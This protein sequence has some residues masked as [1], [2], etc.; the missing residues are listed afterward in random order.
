MVVAMAKDKSG[1]WWDASWSVVTG[2]S[3]PEGHVPDGCTNCW[4]EAMANRFGIVGHPWGEVHSHPEKLDWPLQKKK[5]MVWAVSLLGDL[6]HP[7]VPDAFI[8]EVFHVMTGEASAE[9]ATPHVYVILTKRPERVIKVISGWSVVDRDPMRCA[10]ALGSQHR[11]GSWNRVYILASVWDQQ[12]TDEAMKWLCMV[13]DVARIGLHMEPLLGPVVLPETAVNLSWVVVGAENG[14]SRRPMDPQW[15]MDLEKQCETIGIPFWLK[16][17]DPDQ[18]MN[19]S[20]RQR[21]WGYPEQR[22]MGF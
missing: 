12:S 7:E 9:P 16:Q 17:W 6:F 5:P 8:D 14:S 21:P 22:D 10:L 1:Q 19:H 2:C 4:A 18:P 13:S 11:L 15:A 3:W 20:T